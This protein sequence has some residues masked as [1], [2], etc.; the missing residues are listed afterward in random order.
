[1]P[2]GRPPKPTAVLELTGAFKKNPAR[3]QDRAEE[4]RP[5]NPVGEPPPSLSAGAKKCWL[6]IVSLLPFGVAYDS[7]RIALEQYAETLAFCRMHKWRADKGVDSKTLVRMEAMYARFGMTPADRSRIK[8]KPA[9]KKPDTP[10]GE[11]G[12]LKAVG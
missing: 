3:A 5:L 2:A 1:M 10:Y 4:P 8:V 7:D 12:K 6:E 11:F 9:E